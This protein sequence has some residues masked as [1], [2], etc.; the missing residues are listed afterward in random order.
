MEIYESLIE[1]NN[2]EKTTDISKKLT[3]I[4]KTSL[5]QRSEKEY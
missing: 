5:C 2:M 3:N 1:E 4:Q